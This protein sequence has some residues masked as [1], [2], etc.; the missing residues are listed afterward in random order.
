MD[1][2]HP[3]NHTVNLK[4][5]EKAVE[6]ENDD[7]TNCNSCTWYS[8]LTTEWL[9][10][11][12]TRGAHSNSCIVEIG[13]NTKK[14]PRDLRRLDVTTQ[15]PVK[16]PL[17]TLVWKNLKREQMIIRTSRDLKT[18]ALL[19]SVWILRRVLATWGD[20]L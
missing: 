20:L 11:N 12:E 1:F 16:N 10:N 14:G 17:L 8:S 5:L 2:A 13:Q 18:T 3:A 15:T 6:H 4:D 19:R 9:R 7:Y